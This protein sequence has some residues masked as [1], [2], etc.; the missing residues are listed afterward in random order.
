MGSVHTED[1]TQ[2][3]AAKTMMYQ[4]GRKFVFFSSTF[5]LERRADKCSTNQMRRKLVWQTVPEISSYA[6]SPWEEEE[7]K[8]L[9][10]LPIMHI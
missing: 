5:V 1:T 9:E 6:V 8:V 7:E 3:E 2:L 10:H 4:R